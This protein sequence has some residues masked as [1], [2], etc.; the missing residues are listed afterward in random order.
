MF[1]KIK[2]FILDRYEFHNIKS[3]RKYIGGNWE[4]WH[5]D[6]THSL[7]WFKVKKIEM[8]KQSSYRPGCA[9][10]TPYC[11]YYDFSYEGSRNNFNYEKEVRL[12]KFKNIIYE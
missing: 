12:Q 7:I 6:C 3:V 10:G 11:E 8:M 4:Q 1:R 2:L 9:F 5:I